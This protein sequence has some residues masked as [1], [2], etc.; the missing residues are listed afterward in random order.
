M[1]PAF[2]A[3]ADLLGEVADVVRRLPDEAYVAA[4]PRGVSGSVGAHVRHC[5]DHVLALE[6]ALAVREIDYDVRHRGGG[7]ETDRRAAIAALDAAR[8]RVLTLDDRWL[9]RS[10]RVRTQLARNGRSVVTQSTIGRELAFVISHTIHHNA[11][12]GVLLHQQAGHDT[13]AGFGYAPS[14]P[15]A[16]SA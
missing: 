8:V 13:P 7:L 6:Q 10:V 15:C 14:T 16:L 1:R 9:T 12:I 3:L 11:T 4:G 2:H 5:L